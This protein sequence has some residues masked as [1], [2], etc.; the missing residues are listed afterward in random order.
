MTQP[1]IP[2]ETME[3]PL[4][5]GAGHLRRTE[6]LER[7]GAKDFARVAQLSAEEA[8]R[9]LLQKSKLDDQ[10]TWARFETELSK[11]L[12]IVTERH[13]EEVRAA[14]TEKTAIQLRLQTT[15]KLAGE[16]KTLDVQR[17]RIELEGSLRSEQSQ[18]EDLSR[19]VE[20]YFREVKQLRERNQQLEI[21]LAKVARVGKREEMGQ[22]PETS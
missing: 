7:L 5:L 2:I 9:L 18:R 8:F 13:K 22:G 21:D 20:D 4:C 19:R 17:V 3:C 15:E 10:N 14:Q 11:R 16:Q 12:A 6:V 1:P